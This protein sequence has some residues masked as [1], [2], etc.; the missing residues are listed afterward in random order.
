[1]ENKYNLAQT[2][3]RH[4]IEEYI[5]AQSKMVSIAKSLGKMMESAVFKKISGREYAGRDLIKEDNWATRGINRDAM[6]KIVAV[7]SRYHEYYLNAGKIFEDSDFYTLKVTFLEN[8]KDI[9]K[10]KKVTD[11]EKFFLN[12]L[13]S[14][15]EF[16]GNPDAEEIYYLNDDL[17]DLKHGYNIM[18]STLWSFGVKDMVSD[19]FFTTRLSCNGKVLYY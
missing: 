18:Y 19:T 5:G 7:S 12:R 9:L 15:Y 4:A 16:P 6:F 8:P 3:L 17:R 10:T 1:M 13:S 2:A 11:R 14:Y